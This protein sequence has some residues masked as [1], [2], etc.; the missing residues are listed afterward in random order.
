MEV[1]IWSDVA[2]P[3]CFVGK[4][5]FERALSQFEHADEVRVLWRSFELDPQAPP[6]VP[7]ASTE[8]LA[9]KYGMPVERAQEMNTQLTELAAAEGLDYHL[10]EQRL[11]STFDAHRLIHLAAEHGLQDQ[12]K[13]R[14]LRARLEE[15]LLVS[16]PEVLVAC[17]LDVGLE[18][19][20]VREMLAADT[21][22]EAVRDDEESARA[23]GIQGVP[24]FVVDRRLGASG[25]QPPELLLQ[26]LRQGWETASESPVRQ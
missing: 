17:A 15:A 20:E 3:W 7:G 18:E 13:E 14:L 6:E 26:L 12:M 11:G 23:L 19:P 8:M 22:R 2:C 9:K 21:Y 16:D 24:M 10:A 25:A 4:R 1:E 5:R